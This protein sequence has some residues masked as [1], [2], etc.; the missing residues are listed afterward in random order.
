M[1]SG[2]LQFPIDDRENIIRT[3]RDAFTTAGASRFFEE[4]ES[5]PIDGFWIMAPLTAEI[6]ALEKHDRS[7][8]WAVIQGV[9][10]DIEDPADRHV[11]QTPYSV[12]LIN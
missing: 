9:P 5:L 3:D 11:H 10:L 8:T 4:Q 1:V 7:N 12:R 6:A 2:D